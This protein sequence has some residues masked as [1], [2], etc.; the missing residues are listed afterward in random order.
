MQL[1]IGHKRRLGF[2]KIIPFC[3]MFLAFDMHLKKWS[4]YDDQK[5]KMN[6]LKKRLCK[7]KMISI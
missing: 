2:V 6:S 3:M 5:V 1:F 7:T 4:K